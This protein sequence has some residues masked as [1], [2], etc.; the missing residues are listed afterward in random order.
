MKIYLVER[1][2]G[3][4]YDEYDSFVCYAETSEQAKNMA[5]DPEFH[6]WKDG[7]ACYSY[8]EQNPVAVGWPWAKSLDNVLVREIGESLTQEAKA[9]EVILASF[10]AG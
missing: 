4:D 6:M 10:N 8:R 2:D 1:T 9:G 5:P 7:V 3:I